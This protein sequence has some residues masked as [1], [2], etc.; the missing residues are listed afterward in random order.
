MIIKVKFA[1]LHAPLFLNGKNHGLKLFSKNG[2][3]LEYDKEEK[4][5][6]VNYRGSIAHLPST[7]VHSY[8]PDSM[9]LSEAAMTELSQSSG[10][11]IAPTK[12]VKAQ[13]SGPHDHVFAG[14]GA[15]KARD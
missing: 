2:I 12:K 11:S 5:L 3:I 6:L 8:E 15:G 9:T 4:E 7:S 13:V 1:E 14:Q 10:P